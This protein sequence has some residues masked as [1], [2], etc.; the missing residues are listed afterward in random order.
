ML[1][2]IMG[3]QE[4]KSSTVSFLTVTCLSVQDKWC[5]ILGKYKEK[6]PFFGVSWSGSSPVC[7][8]AE[9][10][11]RLCLH[12]SVESVNP[13]AVAV[14]ETPHIILGGGKKFKAAC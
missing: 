1:K 2:N 4:R 12:E 14:T 6:K 5:V 10:P 11:C 7:S 3:F 13:C 8:S 9:A